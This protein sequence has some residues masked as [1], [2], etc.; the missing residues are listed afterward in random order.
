M[1][2]KNLSLEKQMCYYSSQHTVNGIFNLQDSAVFTSKQPQWFQQNEMNTNMPWW[3]FH[4]DKALGQ[5]CL[6]LHQSVR[7]FQTQI[8]CYISRYV[9]IIIF[10]NRKILMWLVKQSRKYK[11]YSELSFCLVWIHC[12]FLVPGLILF[13]SV[14]FW[15][16]TNPAQTPLVL[17]CVWYSHFS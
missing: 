17:Q 9:S 12:C 13:D 4:S 14:S 6:D 1:L 15:M 10:S 5:T 3:D 2:W 16:V 8:S 11:V 7:P